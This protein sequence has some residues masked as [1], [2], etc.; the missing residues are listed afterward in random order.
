MS[1]TIRIPEI[2]LK[3]SDWYGWE[4]VAK[5]ARSFDGVHIPNFK[6]GV[7]E[8]K[9]RDAE[10]RLTIGKASDLR[11]RVR[12]GLVKGKTAHSTGDRIRR[13]EDVSTIVIR[14]AETSRPAAVEEDLHLRYRERF[15]GL[16][17]HTK[18]T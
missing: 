12:Q 11:M 13:N 14:W 7:Y 9:H 8:A 5:D 15:G 2:E 10:E 3:W 16:P 6:P 17:K 18:S 4:Q 1:E